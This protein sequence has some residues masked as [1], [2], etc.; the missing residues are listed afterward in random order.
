MRKEPR[1]IPTQDAAK[2]PAPRSRNRFVKWPWARYSSSF[3]SQAAARDCRQVVAQSMLVSGIS[4]ET[5]SSLSIWDY[6]PEKHGFWGYAVG[7]FY[8]NLHVSVVQIA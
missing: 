8:N 1:R 5:A 6:E 4:F 3:G 7:R 2:A